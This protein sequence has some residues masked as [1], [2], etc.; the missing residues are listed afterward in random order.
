MAGAGSPA[1]SCA[2][3]RA[4][5]A[6]AATRPLKPSSSRS[7]RR[8]GSRAPG[9]RG[10]VPGGSST[11]S[12]GQWS[13]ENPPGAT[14]IRL[15]ACQGPTRA[16]DMSQRSSRAPEPAARDQWVT[17]EAAGPLA[18]RQTSTSWNSDMSSCK[19]SAPAPRLALM[20]RC[21]APG[22]PAGA[23]APPPAGQTWSF[24]ARMQ[25][26]SPPMSSG[27]PSVGSWGRRL[28]EKKARR[29]A[30]VAPAGAYTLTN[31]TSWPL[32][33]TS[34]RNTRPAG[35]TWAGAAGAVTTGELVLT[36]VRQPREWA[37]PGHQKEAPGQWAPAEGRPAKM[38]KGSGCRSAS[39]CRK[40][41]S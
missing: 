18:A 30:A 22:P 10:T 31:A 2:P 35:S 1:T 13:V 33:C 41:T 28:S 19:A 17:S 9:P 6:A 32:T 25:L 29:S 3:A 23:P 27:R 21:P 7:Q 24:A 16:A 39:S 5:A 40:T 26:K 12:T 15:E 14:R 20:P 11:S 8:K 38:E 34:T 4:A 37:V 36:S